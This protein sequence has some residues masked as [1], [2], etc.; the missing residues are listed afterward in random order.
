MG[1]SLAELYRRMQISPS[2]EA[3]LPEDVGDG[4]IARVRTPQGVSL[5]A[6]EMRYHRDTPVEGAVG[7]EMR[8]L[9]CLGEGVEWQN[10]SGKTFCVRSS[11]ACL[12]IGNG[13]TER[14]CY[15]SGYGYAFHQVS[16]ARGQAMSMIQ[17]YLPGMDIGGLVQ[18][19]DGRDFPI[20][21]DIRRLL[22]SF[23]G[24]GR[25]GGLGLM[26]LECRAHELMALCLEQALGF[27]GH[28]G[29]HPDDLSAVRSVRDRIEADASS[30]LDIATLAREY[31]VS[32]SKLSRDF[33]RAYGVSIHACVIEARLEEAA[34]L[35]SS[36]QMSVAEVAERVGYA[37]HSQF[38]EAFRRRFGVLPKDY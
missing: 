8:L 35:L 33:K 32:T 17:P 27:D 15:G 9:F 29:L 28:A 3:R 4:H 22:D 25:T 20:T 24:L 31:A 7:D 2:L 12:C 10:D 23:D 16:I 5:S 21:R 26:R 19:L 36:G 37:K 11:H 1:E 38:S 14:M 34:R 13:T 30:V 6:W 18:S